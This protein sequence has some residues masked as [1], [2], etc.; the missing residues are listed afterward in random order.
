MALSANLLLICLFIVLNNSFLITLY[1]RG[2]NIINPK[3][4]FR[5]RSLIFFISFYTVR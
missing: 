1:M 3:I 5:K 4:Q 2:V